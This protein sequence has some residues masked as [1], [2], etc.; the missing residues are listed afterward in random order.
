MGKI[1]FFDTYCMK[2]DDIHDM[3]CEYNSM[4]FI[5]N[6]TTHYKKSKYCHRGLKVFNVSS[7]G[8]S[9]EKIEGKTLMESFISNKNYDIFSHGAIWLANYVNGFK[10]IEVGYL[11]DFTA[12]NI[13]ISNQNE[14]ILIDQLQAHR[15]NSNPEKIIS[16]YILRIYFERN[17][18]LDFKFDYLKN[19]IEIYNSVA[20]NNLDNKLLSKEIKYNYKRYSNK[21]KNEIMF[22]KFILQI[23]LFLSYN[24][25]KFRIKRIKY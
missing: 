18:S 4:K 25:L 5:S 24:F 23:F 2:S 14:I 13:M 20:F 3:Y 19:C 9:M 6:H 15:S 12:Q 8:Y 11:Q 22:K 17:L 21:L 16:Y 10:K 1:D 7:I